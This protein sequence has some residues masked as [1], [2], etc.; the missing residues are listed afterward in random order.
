MESLF[1]V[2]TDGWWEGWEEEAMRCEEEEG[3]TDLSRCDS[4]ESFG[5]GKRFLWLCRD[6]KLSLTLR[7]SNNRLSDLLSRETGEP[8]THSV[9]TNT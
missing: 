2:V 9:W 8:S 4:S 6:A 7:M 1:S 5:G 3:V